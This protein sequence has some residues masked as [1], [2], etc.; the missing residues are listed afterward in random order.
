MK[1]QNLFTRFSFAATLSVLFIYGCTPDEPKIYDETGYSGTYVGYHRL[2][3]SASLSILGD[4]DFSFYDTLVVTNG[5][6]ST[7]GKLFAKSSY[8]GGSTI[9]IDISKSSSNITPKLIGTIV[10]GSTILTDAKIA[11]GSNAVWNADK[12]AIQLK[13]TAGATF[14][15]IVLPPSLKLWGDFSKI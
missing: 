13:L 9:E 10:V 15:V 4:I 3:D 6:D 7:D 8:L 2:V 1:K 14:G 11:A 12:S 5:T